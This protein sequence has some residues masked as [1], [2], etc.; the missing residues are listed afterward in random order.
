MSEFKIEQVNTINTTCDRLLKEMFSKYE[1][2]YKEF[3]KFFNEEELSKQLNSKVDLKLFDKI[4]SIKAEKEDIGEVK[5]LIES[6]NERVKHL[7][8]IQHEIAHSLSP[9]KNSIN[10]FC[11][12]S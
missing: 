11:V 5:E 6:L 10:T 7:S 4:N 9:I 2:V 8:I 12:K 1:I 3:K